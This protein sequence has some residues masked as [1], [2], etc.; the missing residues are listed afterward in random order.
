MSNKNAGG[1]QLIRLESQLSRSR[2]LV[3]SGYAVFIWSIAYMIP[4]LYWAL[5]GT[6]G[7]SILKPSV[8]E[9]PQW[10]LINWL[11]SAFLTVAGFLG[12]A[13]IYFGNS[14]PL[15]WL[16]LTITLAGSSVAASH[17]IY[18]II[19]RLLQIAGVVNLESGLFNVNEHAFV[20]WDLLLFEPWFLIEGILLAVLG[21]CSFNKSSERRIWL[22]LCTF[23]IIIGLVTGLIGVRFA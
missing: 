21:W 10:E 1:P 23:G 15:K 3:W 18:G 8:L 7:M 9:L 4:H 13:L 16:L 11:A 20:L 22:I 19:Y 14:K 12:I 2:E 17:G 6:I 5:G